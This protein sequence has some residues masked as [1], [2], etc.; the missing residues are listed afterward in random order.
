[1]TIDASAIPTPSRVECEPQDQRQQY[2][3]W[4]SG[5][6]LR[7]RDVDPE[8]RPRRWSLIYERTNGAVGDALRQHFQAHNLTDFDWLPPG[9]AE[10]VRVIHYEPPSIDWDN[11]TTC[12]ARV[13]F[14]EVLAHD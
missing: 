14:E 3:A 9:E 5:T 1:M 8:N 11:A 2:R 10:L 4:R 6:P 13:Y 7:T 12:S